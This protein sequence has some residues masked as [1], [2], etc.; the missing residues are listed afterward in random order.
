MKFAKY[1][2]ALLVFCAYA[3]PDTV[4]AVTRP[5]GKQFAPGVAQ[6]VQVTEILV[7][8][9]KQAVSTKIIEE[10]QDH[11]KRKIGKCATGSQPVKLVVRLDNHKEMSAGAT[12]MIGDHIQFAGLITFY[13][14]EGRLLAEYYNDEFRYSGGL[15]GMAILSY[16]SSRF[17]EQ[18]VQSMCEGIFA[19][20]LPD[21][22][23]PQTP[24]N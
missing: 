21:D 14:A 24:E 20:E 5:A 23:T 4:G 6:N 17:S 2:L 9:R 8:T 16:V 3:A 13:D 11:L 15:L 1:I 18:F 22:P 12:I 19:V 7:T 10:V